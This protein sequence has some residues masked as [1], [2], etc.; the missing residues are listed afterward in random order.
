MCAPAASYVAANA[1][2]SISQAIFLAKTIGVSAL[3]GALVL[4]IARVFR[5]KLVFCKS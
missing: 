1:L 3:I 2:A 5:Y 4:S